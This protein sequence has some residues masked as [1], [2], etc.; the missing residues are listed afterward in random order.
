MEQSL[1]HRRLSTSVSNYFFLSGLLCFPCWLGSVWCQLK[2]FSS[3]IG[4]RFTQYRNKKNTA[5]QPIS[6]DCYEYQ[7]EWCPYTIKHQLKCTS[8]IARYSQ[9]PCV[10]ICTLENLFGF[11]I[12]LPSE[13]KQWH[14]D[15]STP[16]K[17]PRN[18]S[19]GVSNFLLG[20]SVP[21]EPENLSIAPGDLLN[22]FHK[23]KE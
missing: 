12:S 5:V 7:M 14:R 2:F 21:C 13:M 22:C 4:Y 17:W 18:H 11:L 15:G 19:Y 9:A 23:L 8:K 10:A 3:Y 20:K 6:Q 1:E 16:K